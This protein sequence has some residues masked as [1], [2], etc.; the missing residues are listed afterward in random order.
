M[1]LFHSFLSIL[2]TFVICISTLTGCQKSASQPEKAKM[3]C[4]FSE[5]TWESSYEDMINLEGKDFESY[6]SVYKGTTY[7]YPKEYLNKKGTIK[8][9]YDDKEAL[10][11]IA[12]VYS[13]DKDAN[14]KDLY[15]A[16]SKDVV[17]TYGES[18]YNTDQQTNYGD[19]WYLDDGHII[20]SVMTTDTQKALQ[21]SYQSPNASGEIS[22]SD[23]TD[24]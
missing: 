8:Y 5:L 17:D 2:L 6:D 10:M 14:L 13:A 20:L 3:T 9:M 23:G 7:A 11:C 22:S 15:N 24:Q 4:P 19:V 12:W 16:I 1:R 18:G 21:Y